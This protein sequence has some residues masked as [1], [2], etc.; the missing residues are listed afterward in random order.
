MNDLA[1]F[2][3]LAVQM[4]TPLLLATLG[5][6]LNE[7]VGHLNLGIE[8]M[9]MVG[10]CFGFSTAYYTGSPMLAILAAGTAGLILALIYALVTVT[11]RGD[12]TVTGFA[13]TIF[14]TG[15]ANFTGKNL[16]SLT[17]ASSFTDAIGTKA[18]PLLSKI[19][20]FGTVLFTQSYFVHL[21][22]LCAILLYVYL[23]KTRFGLNM[24]MV[25]ENPAAA[26]AS[27]VNISL[28]KY[29]H[30]ALG[31]FLCGLGGAYLSLVYVPRWQDNITAGMGWIAVAL[32]IFS[33]WNPLKAI[34]GACLFGLLRGLSIKFQNITFTI[35][36][37]PISITSQIMDML[38]YVMTICVLIITTLSKRRENQSPDW[39]GK[40]YFREDR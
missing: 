2:L 1:L 14:G 19:P 21:S 11:L 22:I 5:G 35:A 15:F 10:A 6:I 39:L 31:G 40:S 37:V 18:I 7:K 17:L 3:Q 27:G 26:D 8:G 23:K 24:R 32:V 20:F 9:M 28:Y 34:F 12:Q 36:D 4:G 13:I 30:I 38:P 29:I 25:G 16:A 33:S